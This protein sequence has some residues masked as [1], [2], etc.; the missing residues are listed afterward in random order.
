[1]RWNINRGLSPV[2]KI[3]ERKV[4]GHWEG[5]LIAGSK[6]QLCIGMLIERAT[7]YLIA[8][9]MKSMSAL[10]VRLGIEEKM[11][12]LPDFLRASMT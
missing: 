1:L 4:A 9:K 10:N 6:N 5:D 12:T 11:K 2:V 7:G 3:Q 8:S